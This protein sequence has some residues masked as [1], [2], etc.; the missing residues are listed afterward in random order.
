MDKFKRLSPN[1]KSFLE[2]L[3]GRSGDELLKKL[4]R[5]YKGNFQS[6]FSSIYGMTMYEAKNLLDYMLLEINGRK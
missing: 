5:A 3:L 2:Q 6:E 4:D 1:E